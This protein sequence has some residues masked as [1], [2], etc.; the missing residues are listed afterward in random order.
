MITRITTRASTLVTQV[1]QAIR[2]VVTD[3]RGWLRGVWR[4]HRDRLNDDRDYAR[5]IGAATTAMAAL[6]TQDPAMLAVV[7]AAVALHRRSPRHQ[8]SPRTASTSPYGAAD[9]PWD[10]DPDRWS[11]VSPRWDGGSF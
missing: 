10:P 2:T 9:D 7:A 6:F 1:T 11:D 5:A 4:Q 3:L 8:A